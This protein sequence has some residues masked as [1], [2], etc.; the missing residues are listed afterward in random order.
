MNIQAVLTWNSHIP[1][2]MCFTEW[3]PDFTLVPARMFQIH[4]LD[5]QCLVPLPQFYIGISNN[6]LTVLTYRMNKRKYY[7][8]HTGNMNDN[9]MSFWWSS[10]KMLNLHVPQTLGLRPPASTMASVHL[11]LF[12]HFW[13][14]NEYNSEG[15]TGCNCNLASTLSFRSSQSKGISRIHCPISTSF[16]LL[17]M[18]RAQQDHRNICGGISQVL[19]DKCIKY[20]ITLW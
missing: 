3:V 16:I 12:S 4:S 9:F 11:F 8:Q 17:I 5:C 13:E 2:C 15:N 20:F 6:R 14:S 10:S 1:F 7:Y 18:E 19:N